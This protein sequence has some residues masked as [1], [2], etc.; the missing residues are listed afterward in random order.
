MRW[1]QAD[2]RAVCT[3]PCALARSR[4]GRAALALILRGG[5]AG[6][7]TEGWD[8]ACVELHLWDPSSRT[9]LVAWGGGG[10]WGAG[11]QVG[12]G[13]DLGVGRLSLSSEDVGLG[14]SMVELHRARPGA[15]VSSVLH[16]ACRSVQPGEPLLA[17]EETGKACFR[18]DGVRGNL[19]SPQS[20]LSYVF[21]RRHF[22]EKSHISNQR[23]GKLDHP[24]S[25]GWA[26]PNQL[27]ALNAQGKAPPEGQ[28]S[29]YGWPS[30]CS[31]NMG[32]FPGLQ[33]AGPHDGEPVP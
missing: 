18:R 25:C 21:P 16:G 8:V 15:A 28:H 14:F 26:T 29:A 24:M 12:C 7:P 3:Q 20:A 30:V 13:G 22:L 5:E 9:G 19:V 1:D 27:K 2:D 23:L 33:P 17:E 32:L 10:C 4:E 6:Y 11:T 31:S